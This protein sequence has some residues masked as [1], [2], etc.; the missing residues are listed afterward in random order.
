MGL[1]W[2]GKSSETPLTLRATATWAG[3]GKPENK[4]DIPDLGPDYKR[5]RSSQAN[6]SVL[7]MRKDE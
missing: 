6:D 7:S 5:D 2:Q 4:Q 3:T 1:M